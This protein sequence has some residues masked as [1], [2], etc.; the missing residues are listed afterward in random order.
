M[1]AKTIASL[2]QLGQLYTDI[3]DATAAQP[4][5]EAVLQSSR[6]TFGDMHSSTLTALHN[7]GLL[8]QALDH[9]RFISNFFAPPKKRE[10]TANNW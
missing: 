1:M 5:F 6:R 9:K 8:H 2:N 7:Y 10:I 4:L 3:G